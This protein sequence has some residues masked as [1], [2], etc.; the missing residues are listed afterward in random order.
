M[1]AAW[2]QGRLTP[3]AFDAELLAQGLVPSPLVNCPG[4]TYLLV[5]I[6]VLH[7]LDLGLSQEV[8]GSLFFECMRDHLPGRNKDERL[9]ELQQELKLW[10]ELHRPPSELDSL[11]HDMIVREGKAPRLRA[12]GAET[13]HLVLFG[14]HLATKFEGQ[15][16][17]A[18]ARANLLRSLLA[19]YQCFAAPEFD[20]SACGA[21]GRR[22]CVLHVALR[23]C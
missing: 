17:H 8:L 13:R 21:A 19:L 1:E 23:E 3:G 16:P 20:A 12:K 11:T 9:E 6:D 14:V 7:A 2:R 22:V 15:G 5:A 18:Q 10:Y 4:F